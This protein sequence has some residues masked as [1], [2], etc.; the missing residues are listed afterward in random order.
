MPCTS[1]PIAAEVIV[2]VGARGRSGNAIT[3]VR[4]GILLD[5]SHRPQVLL[6]EP[7]G[8]GRP[9]RAEDSRHAEVKDQPPFTAVP[10]SSCSNE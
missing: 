8:D 9:E 7:R 4:F 3:G 5:R 1:D 10:V 2:D 6:V